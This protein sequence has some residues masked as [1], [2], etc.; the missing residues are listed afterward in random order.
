MYVLLWLQIDQCCY[1]VS[2]PIG[3]GYIAT[4]G[5]LSTGCALS[6]LFLWFEVVML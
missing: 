1:I 2:K 4:V 5:S 6:S 3:R